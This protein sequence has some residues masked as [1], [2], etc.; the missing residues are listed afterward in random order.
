MDTLESLC[1]ANISQPILVE[2]GV[3]RRNFPI[4]RWKTR[5]CDR[6]IDGHKV[7]RE[8]ESSQDNR[9]LVAKSL[10]KLGRLGRFKIHDNRATHLHLS[11]PG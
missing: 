7:W 3:M 9:R 10:G 2:V 11:R 1:L 6:Q 8:A 5:R 4:R